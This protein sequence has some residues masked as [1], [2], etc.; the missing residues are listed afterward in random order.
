MMLYAKSWSWAVL[1]LAVLSTG[2]VRATIIDCYPPEPAPF[3]VFLN[4]L[5]DSG[6]VFRSRQQMLAF[7][8]RLHEHLDQKRDAE[9]AG[10]AAAPFRVAR[11][12]GRKPRI[13]GSEFTPTLVRSLMDQKVVIEVWGTLGTQ[14]I[15]GRKQAT[16]QM[17]YLIVPIR[18]ASDDGRTQTPSLHRFN[19][20]DRDVKSDD[21]LGLIS[22]LD[23]QAFIAAAIG[24]RAFD[25]DQFAQA[26]Q[27]LCRSSA[28]LGAI[29][30]RLAQS[31]TTRAQS[32]AT[33]SLRTYVVELAGKARA[34][35]DSGVDK[36]T[37]ASVRLQDPN[38][39]C[40]DVG[41]QP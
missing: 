31:N 14:Q 26:H 5:D 16:A 34:Q 39:P 29:K 21:Y 30:A 17:N 3:I 41:G 19:Y 12:E 20:P 9:M 27:F 35:V 4:E 1:G 33:E 2:S 6:Q 36:H 24:V 25:N 15:A 23:L 7:F 11:C 28:Q 13:D 38:N 32:V 40:G 37:A 8:N 22:N 18:L 10:I